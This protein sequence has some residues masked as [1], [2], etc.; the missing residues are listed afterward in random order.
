MHK[1]KAMM[2]LVSRDN[3]IADEPEGSPAPQT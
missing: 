2:L 3:A 1:L